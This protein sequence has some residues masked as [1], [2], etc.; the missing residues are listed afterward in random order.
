MPVPVKLY[1]LSTCSHCRRTKRLL[2]QYQI[3]YQQV[4]VDSLQGQSQKE[5]LADVKRVNPAMTFPTLVVGDTVIIGFHEGKIRE[6]LG[7]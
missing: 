4:D 7:I 5:Q 2:D 6:A 3:Q 1:S